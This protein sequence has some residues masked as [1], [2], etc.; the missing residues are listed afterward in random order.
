VAQVQ[1]RIVVAQAGNPA[2]GGYSYGPRDNLVLG[3]QITLTNQSNTDVTSHEWE[4]VPGPGQTLGAYGVAGTESSTLTLTPPAT[5]GYGD[6]Y[7]RLT[8]RGNPLP[9]G[10]PNQHVDQVL[11]GVRAP[12][13]GYSAGVPIPHPRESLFGGIVTLSTARGVIGRIVEA[14]I[15]LL[16][17]V[18]A[19]G[20]T[21]DLYPIALDGPRTETGGGTAT[22]LSQPRAYTDLTLGNTTS[23]SMAGQL[24][25]CTGTLTV[26]AGCV[27][28]ND[29]GNGGDN[30][31]TGGSGGGVGGQLAA[32][33][34]SPGSIGGGA[35]A[36]GTA[37]TGVTNALGG[38]GG[39][40]GQGSG[41]AAG[42]A[43]GT[44]TLPVASSVGVWWTHEAL[45]RMSAVL[46]VSWT[47]LN[48]GAPGGGGGGSS[49]ADNKVGCGAGQPGGFAQIRAKKVV[50]DATGRISCNGGR[51]GDAQPGG[52]GGGGGGG[53]FLIIYCDEFVGPYANC[54]AAG[55]RGGTTSGGVSTAG[56][57]GDPGKV[58]IFVKG[59]LVY[60]SGF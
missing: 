14:L 16:L 4:V 45:L 42:G 40:G 43:K 19:S 13:T 20:A 53:G 47:R 27:L 30:S 54:T 31:T 35:T 32:G 41:G 33:N 6:L 18:V 39:K 8:V 49:G 21:D 12:M 36:P 5:T 17:L 1:A 3:S 44:A 25:T 46:G 28:H 29:G 9:D 59:R 10:K 7:V 26:G 52:G 57:P 34:A 2:P 50:L 55:G 11:L 60:A 22:P 48:A 23:L 51:G 56:D 58:L 15:A 24:L 38:S 37:G